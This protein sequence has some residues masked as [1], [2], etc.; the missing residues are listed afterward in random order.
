MKRFVFRSHNEERRERIKQ[1]KSSS[2]GSNCDHNNEKKTDDHKRLMEE[3]KIGAEKNEI[4][5]SYFTDTKADL[6]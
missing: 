2:N 4:K 6:L 5:P 3:N 1:T